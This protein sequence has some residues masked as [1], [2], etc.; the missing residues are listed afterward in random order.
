MNSPVLSVTGRLKQIK[1]EHE[2]Y[3]KEASDEK[4]QQKRRNDICKI[5]PNSVPRKTSI[6]YQ[7]RISGEDFKELEQCCS[8]GLIF[9]FFLFFF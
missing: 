7:T 8:S 9:F 1:E 2:K 6:V 5:L 4:E 3:I